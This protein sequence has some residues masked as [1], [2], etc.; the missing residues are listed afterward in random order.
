MLSQTATLLEARRAPWCRACKR[1]GHEIRDGVCGGSGP[2]RE[3][4]NQ[5]QHES[6]AGKEYEDAF[7]A[8]WMGN[9]LASHDRRE[10]ELAVVADSLRDRLLCARLWS[11]LVV[12]LVRGRRGRALPWGDWMF[13]IFKRHGL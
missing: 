10:G 11:F 2:L 9:R 5:K 12:C 6:S 3:L 8:L 1:V 13:R 4:G 7:V